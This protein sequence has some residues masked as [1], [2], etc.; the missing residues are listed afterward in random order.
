[1]NT[2]FANL[3]WSLIRAFLAV[4]ETGSLSAAAR[5]LGTS[6]PTLGRQVKAMEAQ[7]GA[8]LFHRRPRA[9]I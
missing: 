2:S 9:S 6:Q 8:E 4:A 7:L 1:M 5:A 3:D